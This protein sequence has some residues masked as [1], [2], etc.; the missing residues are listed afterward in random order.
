MAFKIDKRG[1]CNTTQQHE[2]FEFNTNSIMILLIVSRLLSPGSKKK[3][4]EEKDRYFERFNSSQADVYRSLSHFS[5]IATEL[6]RYL[7]LRIS[8]KYGDAILKLSIAML[9]I[10]I[11]KLIKRMSFASSACQ[12]KNAR[13]QLCSL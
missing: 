4:F 13:I 10:S 9:R 6:Q 1:C 3:A 8:E 5:E 2:N 11:L 7:N 12:R